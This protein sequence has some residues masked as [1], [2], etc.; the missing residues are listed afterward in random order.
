MVR[1]IRRNNNQ[2]D[3]MQRNRRVTGCTVRLMGRA[4]EPPPGP[5]ARAVNSEIRALQGRRGLSQRQLAAM[6]GETDVALSRILRQE[7][8]VMSIDVFE[9]LCAALEVDPVDV[10]AAA[11]RHR[12]ALDQDALRLAAKGADSPDVAEE[13]YY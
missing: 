8:K 6:A 13:D 4:P 1:L 11:T 2:P 5:L 7:I 3:V 9:K 10:L 12:Q